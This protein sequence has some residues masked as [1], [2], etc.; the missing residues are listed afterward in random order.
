MP[1]ASGEPKNLQAVIGSD[2]LSMS[3]R[4]SEWVPRR[5]ERFEYVNHAIVR[6]TVR[7]DIDL[8]G[9]Y[10]STEDMP[11]WRGLAVVPIAV[12]RRDRHTTFDVRAEDGSLLPR[13]TAH[14]ERAFIF[15]GVVA[16]AELLLDEPATEAT[17]DALYQQIIEPPDAH[18]ADTEQL[19]SLRGNPEF[20]QTLRHVRHFY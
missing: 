19:G 2:L 18:V 5:E 3:H 14:E 10:D 15:F 13:L 6:R 20:A 17:R 4:F 7:V 8:A 11:L 9:F 16:Q 12:L 1:D